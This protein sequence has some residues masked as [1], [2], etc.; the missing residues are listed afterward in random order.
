VTGDLSTLACSE[1]ARSIGEPLPGTA[2]QATAWVVIEQPGAWGAKALLDADLPEGVGSAIAQASRG[3]GTGVL[4]ARH[5]D[6]TLRQAYTSTQGTRVWVADVRGA[7]AKLRTGFLHDVSEVADW[8]F[9]AI[10]AG[11]MPTAVEPTTD[12][13]LLVCTQGHRD[14]CCARIGRPTL[15]ALLQ[16][17]G[18]TRRH[19]AWEASHIGG[20]RFAPTLLAL[21]TGSVHGRV[22]GTGAHL[23]LQAAAQ[24]ELVDLGLRGRTCLSP[25]AQVADVVI[26]Q[27]IS[28]WRVASLTLTPQD[29][30]DGE[31]SVG[32]RHQ[33][34]REWDVL[35]I[36]EPLPG[37][38]AESCGA[39]LR[40]G[41]TW[42]VAAIHSG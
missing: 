40:S 7:S 17:L 19:L 22:D 23:V 5:P 25:P 9:H 32:V 30:S 24:M 34:G 18:S 8:D 35:V 11:S 36:K 3:S 4:L 14:A 13:L 27:Q 26:R 39:E 10:A 31:V 15:D 42:R 2:P 6:R 20:H 38:R 12:P 1:Q 33:D 21:P 28:D 37:P 16:A 29:T 41:F